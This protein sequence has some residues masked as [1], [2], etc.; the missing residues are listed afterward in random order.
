MSPVKRMIIKNGSVFD[1]A[2]GW[3][4]EERDLY[5][6]GGRV[7]DPFQDPEVVIEAGGR[8]VLAG[9]VDPHC[10]LAHPGQALTRIFGAGASEDIGRAYAAAGYVHVHHPF[11]TLVTAASERRGL[12]L[13]PWVDKSYGVVLDL[14][15]MGKA[16][17]GN[18][19]P[20][21]AAE[22][23]ALLH[24]TG[25][26]CLFVP[27]PWLRHRQRHYIQKNISPKKVLEFLSQIEDEE[28]RPVALWWRPGLLDNEI[29]RPGNFHLAGLAWDNAPGGILDRVRGFLDAGGS[30]DLV[31]MCEEDALRITCGETGPSGAMSMDTG[32]G[33]PIWF[34]IEGPDPAQLMPPGR[35]GTGRPGQGSGQGPGGSTLARTVQEDA[36]RLLAMAPE[37]WRLALCSSTPG[38][39]AM[40]GLPKA[41]AWLMSR[42]ARPPEVDEAMGGRVLDLY[43]I[44]RLTRLEPARRLG[45]TDMGHLRVGARAHVAIYDLR[46]GGTPAEDLIRALSSCWC[47]IKDG[48]LVRENGEFTETPPSVTIRFGEIEADVERLAHCDLLQNPTLRLEHLRRNGRR[49]GRAERRRDEH[50]RV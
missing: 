50:D 38:R 12:G 22:A 46:D 30:A 13:I 20:Q 5:L 44:A 45:L 37:T 41:C 42:E 17:R 33:S 32:V 15:D 10:H 43:D 18:D 40:G 2:Q 39:A 29:P 47:L 11:V 9:G 28:L 35:P 8:A 16:I 19:H 36:W 31:A 27:F 25:A 7:S 3:R 24:L 6:S 1:P 23:R 14:R 49:E 21:F 26:L 34:S 48:V 4:R